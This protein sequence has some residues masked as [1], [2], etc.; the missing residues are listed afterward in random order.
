VDVEGVAGRSRKR[1]SAQAEVGDDLSADGV[2]GV[3]GSEAGA[4]LG[5]AGVW[6]SEGQGRGRHEP[7]RTGIWQAIRRL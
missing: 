5:D 7:A 1:G 3:R 4:R 2:A 6:A